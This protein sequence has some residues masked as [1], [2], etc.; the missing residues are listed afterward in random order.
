VLEVRVIEGV[1]LG[2]DSGY[3][4]TMEKALT[5]GMDLGLNITVLEQM[6]V[7]PEVA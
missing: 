3:K 1:Q 7:D 2:R 5:D 6:G 4:P